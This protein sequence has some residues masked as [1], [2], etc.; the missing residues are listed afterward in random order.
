MLLSP[1]EVSDIAESVAASVPAPETPDV[2]ALDFVVDGF[3]RDGLVLV[4]EGGL[5]LFLLSP[6]PHDGGGWG[7]HVQVLVGIFR[8][9]LSDTAC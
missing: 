8:L 3:A 7:Q 6:I 9:R 5:H 2:A 1:P 4:F